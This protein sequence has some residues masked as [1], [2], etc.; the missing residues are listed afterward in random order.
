MSRTQLFLDLMP[1]SA[2]KR[3]E[4]ELKKQIDDATQALEL[5]T[6]EIESLQTGR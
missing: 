5:T 6:R 3:I 4:K 1:L 2:L